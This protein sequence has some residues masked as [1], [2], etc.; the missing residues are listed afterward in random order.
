VSGNHRSVL[1]LVEHDR[2]AAARPLSRR[3]F[4]WRAAALGVAVPA[5]SSLLAACGGDEA[6]TP[7]PTAL[8]GGSATPE[9]TEGTEAASSPT[10][11]G[12][13]AASGGRAIISS[14]AEP[15]TLF[16]GLPAT[17]A[18]IQQILSFIA[19]GLTKLSHPEMEV[20]PDIA[21]AW[22][23][24]SD[25][26]VYTFTLRQ[27]VTFHDGEPL[28]AEDVHF[29][30]NLVTHAEWPGGLDPYLAVIDGAA[31]HKEG[32]TEEISG[33][34][35]LDDYQI[36]FRFSKPDVQFL[37]LAAVRQR[38]LPHHI[39]EQEEPADI[40]KGDF[41]RRPIYTGPFKVDE[42]R[43]GEHIA[44]S[45]YLDHFAGR[46]L[47]DGLVARFVPDPATAIAE[48]RSGAVHLGLVSPDQ[49]ESFRTNAAFSTQQLAG[50]AGRKLQFDLTKPMFADERVRQA[51]SHAIDRETIISTLYRS[52]AEAN[53]SQ[54][55]PLS[56]VYN[57]DAPRFAYDPD[58]A[59]ALLDEAGWA[60]SDSDV[61]VKDGEQLAFTIITTPAYREDALA[62]QP[63]LR[64]IGIVTQI[65]EQGAGQATG[66]LEVGQYEATM[67]AWF[68]FIID[69]RADLQR[70]FEWPR[71]LETTGYSNDEVNALFDQARSTTDPDEEKDLYFRIQEI[72]EG[73]APWVYTWRLNDLLVVHQN[74]V[75]PDVSTQTELYIRIPE[76]HLRT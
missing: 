51:I 58:R 75:V 1:P 11:G 46:P 71:P 53:Y 54:A 32:S 45:A 27:D 73:D 59:A 4:V 18:V 47:L 31:A 24:S 33:I 65:E 76:W 39:L 26:R 17:G 56:W 48:L 22:E 29:T 12:A 10:E 38:I 72:A 5:V 69:P 57:P 34:S 50:S 16:S 68:N 3:A 37:A 64:N 14:F 55:S 13:P 25:A 30:Y 15:A 43:T 49:F 62:I 67:T 44:F 66:P 7:T 40:E 23:V 2:A 42:W 60:R 74:L 70:N 61:R 6:P 21:A 52:L 19:N 41:P 35:V 36:E 63:F 9:A 28:T 8:P 20:T